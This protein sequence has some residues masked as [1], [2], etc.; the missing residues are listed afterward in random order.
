MS[1][2]AIELG[3]ALY[4]MGGLKALRGPMFNDLIDRVEEA[5][6]QAKERR[7]RLAGM[8]ADDFQFINDVGQMIALDKPFTPFFV[9]VI[10]PTRPFNEVLVREIANEDWERFSADQYMIRDTQ[11][12]L[13]SA[14]HVRRDSS[15]LIGMRPNEIMIHPDVPWVVADKARYHMKPL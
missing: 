12:R 1:N 11:L 10:G 2:G 5:E 4:R 7:D 9:V 8:R 14:E 15:H 13:L 3:A 6:A